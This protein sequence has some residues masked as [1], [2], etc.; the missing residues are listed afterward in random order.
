MHSRAVWADLSGTLLWCRGKYA[1]VLL[2][3]ILPV[4]LTQETI[5]V[6]EGGSISLPCELSCDDQNCLLWTY[7]GPDDASFQIGSC[8]GECGSC[9]TDCPLTW[10]EPCS[11]QAAIYFQDT[12]R[13]CSAIYQCQVYEGSTQPYGVQLDVYYAH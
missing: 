8:S 1:T 9:S 5:P 7:K 10:A 2:L 3:I 4:V 6:L 11:E 12:R 13:S